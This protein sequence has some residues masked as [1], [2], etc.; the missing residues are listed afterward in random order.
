MSICVRI[1]LFQHQRLKF[2]IKPSAAWGQPASP[3]AE[4]K[5]QRCFDSVSPAFRPRIF[6]RQPEPPHHTVGTDQEGILCQ[7]HLLM[8]RRKQEHWSD[9]IFYLEQEGMTILNQSSLYCYNSAHGIFLITNIWPS[10]LH[11]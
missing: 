9:C 2:P 1:F 11:P 10:T 6:G 4:Q 8:Q 3:Y 5:C 7:Q